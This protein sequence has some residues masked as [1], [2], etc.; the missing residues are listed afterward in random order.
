MIKII[1]TISDFGA[2]ANF[3]GDVHRTS[4]VIEIP[5]KNI[6]PLLKNHLDSEDQ[7]KW[8]T[9]SFSLLEEEF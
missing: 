8:E 7:R 1:C 2:A 6:P 9:I 4:V 3:H 5:T